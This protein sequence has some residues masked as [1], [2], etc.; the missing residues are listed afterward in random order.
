MSS[1]F[2]FANRDAVCTSADKFDYLHFRRVQYFYYWRHLV[3]S[4]QE[5]DDRRF[6]A[7]HASIRP[8]RSIWKKSHV[9]TQSRRTHDTPRS[10]STEARITE[11]SHKSFLTM[12]RALSERGA[13]L[14]RLAWQ[15]CPNYLD[16]SQG[17]MKIPPQ[18]LI[19]SRAPRNDLQIREWKAASTIY[20]A[21]RN[22]AGESWRFANR[23]N[24]YSLVLLLRW[25]R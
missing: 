9:S 6:D 1:Y 25:N 4:P 8:Y 15:G 12:M 16:S 11:V 23:K 21:P 3:R 20:E 5:C 19:D 18:T 7:H 22:I 2:S 10:L 17:S 24:E 13:N 14:Q